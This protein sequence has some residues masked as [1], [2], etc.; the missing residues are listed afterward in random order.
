M[1]ETMNISLSGISFV[2]EKD[3]YEK[4]RKYT[5]TIETEFS[6]KGEEG[7]EIIYDIEARIA[8]ILLA[9]T[10]TSTVITSDGVDM[11]IAQMG[12]PESETDSN[13]NK[14]PKITTPKRKL[15]RKKE[16]AMFG[17]V[18][19]GIGTYFDISVPL[20]RVGIIILAIILESFD[21]T[22]DSM[23]YI[24]MIYFVCW[25]CTPQAKTAIQ[26]LEMEG[27]D[28]NVSTIENK[29]GTK[30]K[31]SQVNNTFSVAMTMIGRL[32]NFVLQAIVGIISASLILV[33]VSIILVAIF[34]GQN[35]NLVDSFVSWNPTYTFIATIAASVIPIALILL[36]LLKALFSIKINKMVYFIAIPI[37]I[38]ATIFA[39][40]TFL[41]ESTRNKSYDSKTQTIYS[42]KGTDKI[43][44][45]VLSNGDDTQNP[46]DYAIRYK[47]ANYDYDTCHDSTFKVT[48][49]RSANGFSKDETSKL[50]ESIDMPYEI[51]GDTIYIS[52]GFTISGNTKLKNQYAYYT[53]YCPVN[54]EIIFDYSIKY[55]GRYSHIHKEGEGEENNHNDQ[56]VEIRVNGKEINSHGDYIDDNNTSTSND[57]ET[58]SK[59]NGTVE[60]NATNDKKER[61]T[62]K[63]TKDSLAFEVEKEG[64]VE[65]KTIKIN[66]NK[67][68]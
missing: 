23:S 29:Y 34:V 21:K 32:L 30:Q 44:V 26:K 22:E 60:L 50:I 8:E 25:I 16:G 51:K 62:I 58:N 2:I 27:G 49:T 47:E 24:L 35:L 43:Y 41:T 28:I 36:L 11:V 7:K 40:F 39:G 31:Y 5:D 12:Y 56:K 38:A 15:Y 1:K 3:A 17:G 68:E 64:V 4:L 14:N 37:W 13:T 65:R 61:A 42:V 52:T 67:T 20:I 57:T 19:N 9:Q 45:K 66:D 54:S 6:S 63:L 53:F 48:L 33:V 10:T 59:D 46:I 18:I 55:D